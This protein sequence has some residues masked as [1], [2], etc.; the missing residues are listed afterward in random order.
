MGQL[1]VA[2][3]NVNS[4]AARMP[5]VTE[6]LGL[7]APDVLCLQET[8]A[9]DAAFPFEELA[10]LGYE[11]AAT[12]DGAYNG[13]AI[14]SKVGLEEVT[15]GFGG[16]PGFPEPERRSIAATCG[17]LRVWSVYVPN[18]RTLESPHYEYKLAW[19]GALRSAL[20]RELDRDGGL[21]VCGDFN[22][23][24]SDADVWDPAAFVG[25][26]HV[27]EPERRAI[28]GLLDLGLSD[29]HPRALK[30]EPYTYWDYRAGMFHKGEGM[31]ID[32]VLLDPGSAAKVGDAYIDRDARKGSKPSD[33]A[34]VVVDMER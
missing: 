11:A 6:W 18:G 19:L 21:A 28:A 32:L 27:S 9:T 3:W 30:G 14:L 15:R 1:R 2:T 7:A 24:P 31:R 12:G 34:P 29:V 8:K 17:G 16:E 25:S 23:A 5:R 10:A 13:V 4:L 33:H 20:A 22:V 26:T